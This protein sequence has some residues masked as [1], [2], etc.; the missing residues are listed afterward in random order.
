VKVKKFVIFGDEEFDVVDNNN[1]KRNGV[2]SIDDIIN[3]GVVR[4][5]RVVGLVVI[6]IFEL[7]FDGSLDIFKL[8][9]ERIDE[10]SL[11]LNII[12]NVSDIKRIGVIIE[13][14]KVRGLNRIDEIETI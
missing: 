7:I 5:V 14:G 13:R 12:K 8:I 2:S 6:S 9:K 11:L 3:K 10:K 1:L 4:V